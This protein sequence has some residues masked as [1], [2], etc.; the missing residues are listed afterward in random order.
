M[1]RLATSVSQM[2][3]MAFD[4]PSVDDDLRK[5]LA[6]HAIILDDERADLA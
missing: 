5:A 2:L 1:E 6:A 3:A 4:D